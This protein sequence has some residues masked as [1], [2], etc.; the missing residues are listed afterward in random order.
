MLSEAI[1]RIKYA[2]GQ[3]PYIKTFSKIYHLWNFTTQNQS[4]P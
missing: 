2:I 4:L 1:D 3:I